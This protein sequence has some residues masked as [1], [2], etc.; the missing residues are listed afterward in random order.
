MTY[1]ALLLASLPFLA[2]VA[3]AAVY[4]SQSNYL[5]SSTSLGLIADFEGIIHD[6]GISF[7]SDSYVVGEKNVTI[8]SPSELMVIGY[9]LLGGGTAGLVTQGSN[10]TLTISFANA[11]DS[12]G[13][14][15][16]VGSRWGTGPL[17]IQVY[18]ANDELLYDSGALA[19]P[20]RV[21]PN[22]GD[23][24]SPPPLFFGIDGVGEIHKVNVG[25]AGVNAAGVDNIYTTVPEP[26][27][28]A[29][30]GLLGAC[31]LV[32]RRRVK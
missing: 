16:F 17:S 4:S 29:S 5:S 31:A 28:A 23:P 7:L 11:V 22:T 3:N 18:G 6:A 12:V 21:Q 20:V 25:G 10:D 9:R 30:I 1:R 8:S 2:C 27:A 32:R 15:Y 26:S 19:A 14:D 13:F 24:D